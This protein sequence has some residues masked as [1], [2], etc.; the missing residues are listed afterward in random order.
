MTSKWKV[1]A[2]EGG[3][4]T[5]GQGL[6]FNPDSGLLDRTSMDRHFWPHSMHVQCIIVMA[7]ITP[8]FVR[9]TA[10]LPQATNGSIDG[11]VFGT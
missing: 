7:P 2:V 8:S 1:N 10:K 6:P 3:S 5:S 9:G 4:T 11:Y